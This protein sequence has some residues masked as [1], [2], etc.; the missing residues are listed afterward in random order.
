ML[1]NS[2]KKKEEVLDIIRER[3]E[4][5]FEDIISLLNAFIQQFG[6]RIAYKGQTCN[7]GVRNSEEYQTALKKKY[8]IT[9]S[10]LNKMYKGADH[11]LLNRDKRLGLVI[12]FFINS[13]VDIRS[14]TELEV[15]DLFIS[16]N[17]RKK[18][19]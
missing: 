6:G 19:F 13:N 11:T 15:L 4:G 5:T 1:K 2:I 9:A 14:L 8:R 18:F 12:N 16:K 7:K 10:I 17:I 3:V